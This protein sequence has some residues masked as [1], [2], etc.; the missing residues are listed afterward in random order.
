MLGPL[1]HAHPEAYLGGG[2]GAIPPPP[3]R[4][5]TKQKRAKNTL[6]SRD[7]ITIKYVCGRS[8]RYLAF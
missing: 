8:F 3:L 5:G 1:R 4:H 6:K 2:H 7:Q